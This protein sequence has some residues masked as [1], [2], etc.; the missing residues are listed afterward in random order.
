MKKTLLLAGVACLISATASNAMD[1]RDI[2]PII[3]LDYAYSDA[4]FKKSSKGLNNDFN[5]GVLTIGSKMGEIMSV[6]AFYQMAGE[7]KS[8]VGTDKMK[9]EFSAYGIDAYGHMP[10]GCEKKFELL[11]SLGL[12]I[13]DINIKKNG[14]K[15]VDTNR[16]GYRMGLG[17]QYNF[18]DNLA[19]RVMARYNYI[20]NGHLHSMNEVAAGIRYSF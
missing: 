9:A 6:E 2:K 12:G 13:Y 18:T 20:G 17:A 8:T 4:D 10:L 5:S 11:G 14:G 3:G 16:V 15:V 7:Q 1:Y 19:A